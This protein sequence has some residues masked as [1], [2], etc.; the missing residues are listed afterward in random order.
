MARRKKTRKSSKTRSPAQNKAVMKMKE[1]A[2]L[3]REHKRKNPSSTK[4]I[5]TFVK[6]VWKK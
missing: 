6:E 4:K 5:S 3:Y 2:R 1:A